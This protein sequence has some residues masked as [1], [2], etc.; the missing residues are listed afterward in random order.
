MARTTDPVVTFLT[1]QLPQEACEIPGAGPTPEASESVGLG[2]AQEF[3]LLT[4]SLVRLR[5]LVWGPHVQ[6]YRKSRWTRLAPPK[7]TN[8]S[9]HGTK[10]EWMRHYVSPDGMLCRKKGSHHH[11]WNV[12]IKRRRGWG[13][14]ADEA[15]G[16]NICLQEMKA[17]RTR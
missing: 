12:L 7:P 16:S 14:E 10:K 4:S 5:M 6:S 13:T 1:H 17:R 15:S 11:H 9:K 2:W 3:A 8:E